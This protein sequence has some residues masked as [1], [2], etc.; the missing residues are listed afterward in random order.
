MRTAG[1]RVWLGLAFSLSLGLLL[2]AFV[3][4]SLQA[5]SPDYPNRAISLIVPFPPGG[6]TDL[7]A[8]AVADALEKHLKQPVAVVNKVGGAT[9]IAGYA[10]A[11]AKPDGYTLGFFPNP[12]AIPEAYTF[13]QEAP[14]TSK[15]LKH[16]SAALAP[17]ISIAVK[18]DAPWNSFKEL[19]EYAKKNP[20]LKVSTAGKQTIQ[21]M[22]VTTMNKMEKTGF[23][24]VPFTGDATTLP[25]LLGGHVSV[26]AT[27]YSSLKSLADAK[28]IKVLAGITNKRADFAPNVP[29]VVELG[30]PIVYAPIQGLVGPKALPV[31][32]VE[33]LDNLMARICTEPEFKTRI[34]NI[35]LQVTYENSAAYEKSNSKAKDNILAFFKE[36][37]LVK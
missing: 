31:E 9:T 17:M 27:D 35:P 5:A 7:G 4:V 15:D 1:N 36:E 12:A 29:S 26:A 11:S 20:G 30:Y 2:V 25:A 16:I 3:E 8:R 34:R 33:K 21:H 32:I 10:V 24:P 6:S 23:V 13:F 37:G 14:Y 28:K 22:F 18:E 19:V